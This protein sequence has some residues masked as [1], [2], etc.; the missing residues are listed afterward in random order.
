MVVNLLQEIVK[1]LTCYLFVAL[2]VNAAKGGIGFEVRDGRESLSLFLD[3]E[4]KVGHLLEE[5]L[6]SV[7]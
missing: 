5:V 4:F 1:F 7:L 3:C 6:K 2:S